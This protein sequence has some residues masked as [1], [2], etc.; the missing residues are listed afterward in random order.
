MSRRKPIAARE[1]PI[2]ALVGRDFVGV[3]ESGEALRV[4]EVLGSEVV[5]EE[6]DEEMDVDDEDVDVGFDPTVTVTGLSIV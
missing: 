2:L 1:M 6:A 4:L 3:L 5:V